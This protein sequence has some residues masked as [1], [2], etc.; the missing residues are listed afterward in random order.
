MNGPENLGRRQIKIITYREIKKSDYEEIKAI[1]NESFGL[2]KYIENP[3]V[4]K[5][6]LEIYLQSC[7]AEATFSCVAERDKQ[8]IGI[9]LGN[10]KNDYSLLKHLKPILLTGWYSLV[11]AVQTIGAKESISDYQNMQ[12]IYHELLVSS[13]KK[14]DGVLTLFAVTE[15]S[16]GLGVGKKLV[17]NLR[18]YLKSTNTNEIYL[19]TDS[20]CN[21][22]FYDNQGFKRIG[23]QNMQI[24]KEHE[25]VNMDVY[26][27]QYIVD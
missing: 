7:L 25:Q 11:I 1:I 6:A 13:G 17:A 21:V 3:R 2:H 14:F 5:T 24:T 4:L 27:Y 18:E 10:A 20:S 22:G 9:I 19:Y 15:S 23:T 26:L 8:V 12:K 16:R